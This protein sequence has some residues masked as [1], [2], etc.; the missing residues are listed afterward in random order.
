MSPDSGEAGRDPYRDRNLEDGGSQPLVIWSSDTN[1]QA[2][3]RER[4]T[5]LRRSRHKDLPPLT[6]TVQTSFL[7]LGQ[8]TEEYAE[9]MFKTLRA[10]R[11]G[12]KQRHGESRAEDSPALDAPEKRDELT[13]LIQ[14]AVSNPGPG[15]PR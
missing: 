13:K 15:T 2:A 8:P 3:L 9:T 1:D 6:A 12:R 11:I 10:W 7:T 5:P 14:S 4:P